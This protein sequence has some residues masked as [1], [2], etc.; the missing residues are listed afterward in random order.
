MTLPNLPEG[1][2]WEDEASLPPLPQGF[3]WEKDTQKQRTIDTRQEAFEKLAGDPSSKLKGLLRGLGKGAEKLSG[4]L[5]SPENIRGDVLALAGEEK[6]AIPRRKLGE[7]IGETI[8]DMF[9]PLGKGEKAVK[10]LLPKE[11][12]KELFD[13]MK[14]YGFTEKEIAPFFTSKNKW[15]YLQKIA[16]KDDKTASLLGDLY[17]KY[18]GVYDTLIDQGL[19]MPSITTEQLGTF[20]DAIGTFLERLPPSFR[21]AAEQPLNDL[22]R[23]R[24]TPGNLMH[25]VQDI[26]DSWRPMKGGK[27]AIGGMKDIAIDS[28]K[29]MSPELGRDY[30]LANQLYR[31]GKKLVNR[32]APKNLSE[33]IDMGEVF[34]LAQGIATGNLNLI[35]KAIGVAGARTLAREMLINPKLQRITKKLVHNINKGDRKNI[36][37]LIDETARLMEHKDPEASEKLRQ[38]AQQQQK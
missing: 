32:L 2:V 24:M 17:E 34:G 3:M 18:G 10:G 11:G 36:Y 33:L 15:K 28:M 35:Q 1:F 16:K 27:N 29:E 9:A 13:F 6:E 4:G 14:K 37:R 20:E 26:N 38:L 30:E 12:Q 19:E 7:E 21:R 31:E 8:F 25:F 23:S 22:Y 5:R